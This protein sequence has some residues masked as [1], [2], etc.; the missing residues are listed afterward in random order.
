MGMDWKSNAS[1]SPGKGLKLLD[2]RS[3]FREPIANADVSIPNGA[4]RRGEK[5]R[6]ATRPFN[7]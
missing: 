2:G 5:K 4:S 7:A 1:C 3:D 6:A